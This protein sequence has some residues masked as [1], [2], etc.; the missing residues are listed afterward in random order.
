MSKMSTP[1]GEHDL[2]SFEL[3]NARVIAVGYYNDEVRIRVKE[4]TS[5]E[6]GKYVQKQFK[7]CSLN[8]FQW[9]M[10][11]NARDEITAQVDFLRGQPHNRETKTWP[12]DD[13][14]YLDVYN[15]GKFSTT[16]VDFRH[17]FT[18]DGQRKPTRYGI[19][20]KAKEWKEL[21]N[22]C[23]AVGKKMVEV[24]DPELP[25]K[26]IVDI[27]VR[28]IILRLP[29]LAQEKCHGCSIAHGS[30]KQHMSGGCM[31]EWPEIAEL[32][33]DELFNDM[34]R[35]MIIS[36]LMEVV[37]KMN[38]PAVAKAGELYQ[39]QRRAVTKEKIR[40]LV[41]EGALGNDIWNNKME[42][43]LLLRVAGN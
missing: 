1:K 16:L 24:T 39:K 33:F 7:A 3:G 12:L 8:L 34:P 35:D 6:D 9:N 37:R 38:L 4:L 14:K 2:F 18:G 22:V 31:S 32:Y 20:L 42:A 28:Y 23:D 10:I 19:A 30:Q 25:E 29:T 11:I 40:C 13:G 15:F 41:A 27:M 36:V 26:L 5:G 21:C 17:F 43:V